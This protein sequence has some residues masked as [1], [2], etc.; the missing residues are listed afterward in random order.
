MGGEQ[1]PAADRVVDVLGDRPGQ[2]DAVEGAGAAADLVEDHQAAGVALFRM[3]AV[4]VISTMKVLWPRLSSS[5][6]PTRAKRRSTMP[7][8]AAGGDEAADLRQ[9]GD[10]RDLA[11]VR[12]L[13]GHV[14]AGDQEDRA[15]VGAEP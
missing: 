7:I 11:D 15:G 10:Q 12:A 8:R 6:A 4:S 14:R 2:R 9:D 1:G 5:V 13:A 3:L